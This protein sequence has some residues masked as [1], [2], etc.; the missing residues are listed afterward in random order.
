MLFDCFIGDI[1]LNEEDVGD[2]LGV[3]IFNFLVGGVWRLEKDI[4]DFFFFLDFFEE[5]WL[6]GVICLFDVIGD[7]VGGS[8]IEFL[9][10]IKVLILL[11]LLFL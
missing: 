3:L 8:C 4:F 9:F 6:I 2:V 5:V 1:S 10:I 11:F 7:L